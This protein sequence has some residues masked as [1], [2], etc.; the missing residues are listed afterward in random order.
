[1]HWISKLKQNWKGGAAGAFVAVVLGLGLLLLH[2]RFGEYLIQLSYNM[3]FRNRPY[4]IPQDLVIVYLD[5][6]SHRDLEQPYEKP[7][8]RGLYGRLVERL[9]MEHA[10]AVAFDIMFTGTNF[11]HLD[12]D[13]RFAQAIK[14]NGKVVLGAEYRLLPGGEMTIIRATDSFYDGEAAFGFVQ[15]EPDQDFVVR[16]HLHVPRDK[17]GSTAAIWEIVIRA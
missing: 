10:R 17:E 12:G 1:M 8:D 4:S 16:Q 6:T 7:W 5:D 3:P 13:A 9:T 2:L 14:A 11:E 15:L